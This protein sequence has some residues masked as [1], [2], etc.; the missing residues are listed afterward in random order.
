MSKNVPADKALYARVKAAAKRKFKVY[1]S[2]YA[3]Y[4][5]AQEYKRRGGKYRKEK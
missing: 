3:N 1:P 4:W 5:L 2:R